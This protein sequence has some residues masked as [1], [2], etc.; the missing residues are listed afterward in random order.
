MITKLILL[1]SLTQAGDASHIKALEK[2]LS[3]DLK[4]EKIVTI[5]ADEQKDK[6]LKEFEKISKSEKD[7]TKNEI[8]HLFL[9]VGEK[10]GE[11]LEIFANNNLINDK[12][13]V[14]WGTHQFIGK[15]KNYKNLKLDHLQIPASA[16]DS[17]EKEEIIN[18]IPN[19]SKTL[20]VPNSNPSLQELKESFAKWEKHPLV[21]VDK[22]Y[23][24][25]LL[26]GDAPDPSNKMQYFTKESALKLFQH[27]HKIW[28]NDSTKRTVILQNG[29]RTGK[30]DPVTGKV[31]CSHE[32][33]TGEPE[34]NAIDKISSYFSS[35][36]VQ[37]KIPYFFKNFSFELNT[38]QRI[39]HSDFEPILY[40]TYKTKSIFIFPGESISLIGQLPLY[41]DPENVIAFYSSSMNQEHKLALEEAF[42]R[43]YLS[44]FAEA[45]NIISPKQPHKLEFDDTAHVASAIYKGYKQKFLQIHKENSPTQP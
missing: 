28:L 2:Q 43:G 32:Y 16:I 36:R 10:G 11:A 27:L 25:V 9:T 5:N 37:E 34:E 30:Y 13:Y 20:T 33:K 15:I 42:K 29:P 24:T 31:V 3:L 8:H 12:S 35:L 23:I 38:G 1:Y 41:L 14:Y 45:G 21:S 22:K 40:L 39:K 7:P 6:L 4:F 44:K 19:V 18:N 26:P 17:S